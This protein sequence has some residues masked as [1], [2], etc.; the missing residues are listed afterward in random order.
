M[1]KPSSSVDVAERTEELKE[2]TTLSGRE[3]EVWALH[4]QGLTRDEIAERL[5][6]ERPTIDEYVR[7]VR[8][9]VRTAYR[10]AAEVDDQSLIEEFYQYASA[11]EE[12]EEMFRDI[13]RLRAEDI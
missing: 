6:I 7:R 8:Q 2:H 3:S 11:R 12:V 10:T 1:A 9:K 4:E 13:L 5:E